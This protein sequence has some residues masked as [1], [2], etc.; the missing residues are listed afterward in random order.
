METERR[1]YILIGDS[2]TWQ[3]SLKKNLWGFSE[4]SRGSWNTSNLGDNLAFYVT[5]PV[6]KIIG[7]GVVTSKFI[8]ESK[9]WPDEIRFDKALWKY[10]FE[11]RKIHVVENWDEGIPV[12]ATIILNV[13]RKVI[14]KEAF[15]TLLARA[16]IG[17]KQKLGSR[18]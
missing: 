5:S 1:N 13:V 9:V 7:F 15:T 18:L 2:E 10:R 17:W 3:V 8:D 4:R 14:D 11:F 16:E 12:S 6:K